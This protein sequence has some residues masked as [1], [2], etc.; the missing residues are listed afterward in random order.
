MPTFS[1]PSNKYRGLQQSGNI[2]SLQ[3]VPLRTVVLLDAI[4]HFSTARSWLRG[5]TN[6]IL[7]FKGLNI[8]KQG[9]AQ[10]CSIMPA[11]N[12][13]A[14]AGSPELSA[15]QN[16]YSDPHQVDNIHLTCWKSC[17]MA[18]SELC[19]SGGCVMVRT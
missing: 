1:S 18:R 12:G 16:L 7:Q 3:P 15:I 5:R 19:G 17:L 10:I 13:E 14:E 4:A 6:F 2:N 8:C 9:F 11:A